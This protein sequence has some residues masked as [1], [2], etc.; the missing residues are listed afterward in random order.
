M[1]AQTSPED[2]LLSEYAK[3]YE[4]KCFVGRTNGAYRRKKTSK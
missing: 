4:G 2:T 1:E 3:E